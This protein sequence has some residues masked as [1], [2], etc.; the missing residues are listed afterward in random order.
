MKEL[1]LSAEMNVVE[2]A[3]EDVIATSWGDNPFKEQCPNM[4]WPPQPA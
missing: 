2:F 1:Y 4:M 3:V